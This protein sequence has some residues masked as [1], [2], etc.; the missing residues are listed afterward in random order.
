MRKGLGG[1]NLMS[2]KGRPVGQNALPR[3][4]V[5]AH[6]ERLQPMASTARASAVPSNLWAS[7]SM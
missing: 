4:G 7:A 5:I 1:A 2:G 6:V 3:G